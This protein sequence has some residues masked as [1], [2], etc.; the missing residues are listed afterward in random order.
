MHSVWDASDL[1]SHETAGN[2]EMMTEERVVIFHLFIY[3]SFTEYLRPLSVSW[4]GT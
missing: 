2:I 4:K 1:L 3:S